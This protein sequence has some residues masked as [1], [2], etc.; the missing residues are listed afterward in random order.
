MASPQAQA[1]TPQQPMA[2][3]K[4]KEKKQK[5]RRE[6]SRLTWWWRFFWMR[7]SGARTVWALI[8]TIPALLA[9]TYLVL[10]QSDQAQVVA[11]IQTAGQTLGATGLRVGV[12]VTLVVFALASLALFLAPGYRQYRYLHLPTSV[13]PRGTVLLDFENMASNENGERLLELM[14]KHLRENILTFHDFSQRRIDLLYF[15]NARHL[16]HE[17]IPES[18]GKGKRAEW[19][20]SQR[21]LNEGYNELYLNGFQLVNSPHKVIPSQSPMK[22][23]VDRSI[24]LFALE[25]ALLGGFKQE[26]V[27]VSGDG[28]YAPL[29]YRLVALGHDVQVWMWGNTEVYDELKKRIP[30]K[31]VPLLPPETNRTHRESGQSRQDSGSAR[32]ASA[33]TSGSSFAGTA[34]FALTNMALMP[35]DPPHVEFPVLGMKALYEAIYYTVEKYRLLA[36]QP[37]NENKLFSKL[38]S[39]LDTNAHLSQQLL[40]VGYTGPGSRGSWIRSI[41]AVGALGAATPVQAAPQL[42]ALALTIARALVRMPTNR[43]GDI[44]SAEVADTLNVSTAATTDLQAALQRVLANTKNSSVDVRYLALCARV[45]GLVEFEWTSTM[46][47][48]IRSP[49][50]TPLAEQIIAQETLSQDPEATA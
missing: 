18:A 35:Q 13:I 10:P 30:L 23:A 14:L 8:L 39:S 27:I 1:N 49:R 44:L 6:P 25:R 7:H 42:F 15:M 38:S 40:V 12:E 2:P 3:E 50:L 36:S 46:P 33:T 22:E 34:P 26:F 5:Q 16:T 17:N 24:E 45:L 41:G 29:I 48:H 20:A 43:D 47:G 28:D 37:A 31:V 21:R 9:A 11:A 4:G 19:I 32:E